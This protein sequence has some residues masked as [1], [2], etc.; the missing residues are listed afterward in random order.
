M[1]GFIGIMPVMRVT[2][3]DASIAWYQRSVSAELC[4]RAANDGGGENCLLRAGA[5]TLMLSTGEHL[6]SKPSFS[7]TLYFNTVNVRDLY[8]RIHG[9]VQIVW[10]L[11]A[12]SYGT[13]EFGIRDPDGYVLAFAE[14]TND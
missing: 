6:G 8:E 3:L 10:P 14:R 13:I 11:E 12:M 5:V 7:G 4:W 1:T 9:Q 2:D